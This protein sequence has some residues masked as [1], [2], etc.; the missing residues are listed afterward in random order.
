MVMVVEVWE[1]VRNMGCLDVVG[2]DGELVGR[3]LWK[4]RKYCGI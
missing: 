4:M 3:N 2:V 1:E